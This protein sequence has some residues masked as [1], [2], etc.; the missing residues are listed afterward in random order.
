MKGSGIPEHYLLD[1]KVRAFLSAGFVV[2]VGDGRGDGGDDG[3][4]GDDVG[5]PG[6]VWRGPGGVHR[7]LGPEVVL[8]GSAGEH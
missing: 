2:V 8:V 4:E 5:C 7:E 1:G 6:Q 3:R